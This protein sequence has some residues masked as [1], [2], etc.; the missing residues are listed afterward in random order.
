MISWKGKNFKKYF[1]YQLPFCKT[2][3]GNELDFVKKKLSQFYDFNLKIMSQEIYM[4]HL[5]LFLDHIKWLGIPLSKKKFRDK[6]STERDFIC[7]LD[8]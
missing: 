3:F 4:I 6:V 1:P 7:P 5:L 2:R 8:K